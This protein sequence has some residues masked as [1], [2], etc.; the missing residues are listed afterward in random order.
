M[1]LLSNWDDKDLRDAERRG[2]NNAIF[3]DGKRYLFFVDDWGA[4]LGHWGG[5]W[6]GVL[7]RSKWDCVDFYRQSSE[8]VRGV[9]DGE[10]EFGYKGTHTDRMTGG[11]RPSDVRW[12]M[13]YLGRLS[14]NQLHTGLISSGATADEAYFYTKALRMRIQQL[15]DIARRQ[16]VTRAK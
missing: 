3:K 12:L 9:K 1:M 4:S 16:M 2:T 10:V 7:A 14:D 11:I 5:H 8:F 13:Q 6:P 15:H